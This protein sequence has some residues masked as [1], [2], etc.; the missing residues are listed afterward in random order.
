M[1]YVVAGLFVPVVTAHWMGGYALSNALD[2]KK[3]L[4]AV[5]RIEPTVYSISSD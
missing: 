2:K 4:W 1:I 3:N 5:P